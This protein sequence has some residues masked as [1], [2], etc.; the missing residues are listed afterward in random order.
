MYYYSYDPW[1]I[2]FGNLLNKCLLWL[3][4]KEGCGAGVSERSRLQGSSRSSSFGALWQVYTAKLCMV[5]SRWDQPKCPPP[6]PPLHLCPTHLNEHP[7]TTVHIGTFIYINS[8]KLSSFQQSRSV[9]GGK[10][11]STGASTGRWM[12]SRDGQYV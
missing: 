2:W 5:R 9:Y 4:P 7:H 12:Y 8:S 11:S 3:Q 1:Q 6:P 10:Q